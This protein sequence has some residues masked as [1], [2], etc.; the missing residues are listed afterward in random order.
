MQN[1]LK[2]AKVFVYKPCDPHYNVFTV[3]QNAAA[4]KR[5]DEKMITILAALSILGGSALVVAVIQHE[6]NMPP[7]EYLDT[8]TGRAYRLTRIFSRDV[9]I[10]L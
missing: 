3:E 2:N 7:V 9:R 1:I 6:I 10:S 8:N 4:T 5:R